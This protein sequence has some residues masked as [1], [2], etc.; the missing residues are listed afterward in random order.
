MLSEKDFYLIQGSLDKSI[1]TLNEL[2]N[3][4]Y[5]LVINDFRKN[6]LLKSL[7]N[8]N[9]N[10]HFFQP[11]DLQNSIPKKISE[12]GAHDVLFIDEYQLFLE[13]ELWNK[14]LA[15]SE[16]FDHVISFKS[17][18][19]MSITIPYE[20]IFISHLL[21]NIINFNKK[22]FLICESRKDI[23]HWMAYF[24]N[25]Q[26]NACH[27]RSEFVF[28]SSDHFKNWNC[29]LL[30]SKSQLFLKNISTENVVIYDYKSK[31]QQCV[32]L[33]KAC[34]QELANSYYQLG[35]TSLW[36]TFNPY[37]WLDIYP[38]VVIHRLWEFFYV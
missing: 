22:I 29:F 19:N 8:N 28:L 5:V 36:N 4:T 3:I 35:K 13:E 10:I 2:H 20:N 23:E 18:T 33:F 14:V 11:L 30:S 16:Q 6:K 17:V 12:K 7:T 9:Y 26:I 34:H 38:K 15:L 24:Q 27:C 37:Y 31:S 21:S 1:E 25:Y 32:N